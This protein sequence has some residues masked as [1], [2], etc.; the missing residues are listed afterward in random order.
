MS[1]SKYY[2]SKKIRKLGAIYNIIIG[3]RSNGKTYDWKDNALKDYNDK[4]ARCAYI[5]RFDTEIA[6]KNLATLFD[7]NEIE[8]IF[9]L[10]VKL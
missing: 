3:Q 4:K 10:M 7:S 9:N 5:R 1:T 2:S 6:P 8:K